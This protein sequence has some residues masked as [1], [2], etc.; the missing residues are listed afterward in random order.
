MIKNPPIK[1]Y[2]AKW[3]LAPWI[4]SHFPRHT[5]YI[6]V[7]GGAAGVLLQKPRSKLETYNDSWGAVVNFFRVLRNNE[8]E[9]I[10]KIELTPW[11]REEYKNHYEPTD[12]PVEAAR[13]FWVG[14]NMSIGSM[15]FKSCGMRIVKDASKIGVANSVTAE[16]TKSQLYKVSDRLRGTQIESLHYADLLERYEVAAPQNLFYFDPP[17]TSGERVT[18]NVYNT[19]WSN[20][21]HKEAAEILRNSKAYVIVSGYKS[22]LYKELYE[23][24]GWR[25]IDKATQTNGGS[26]VESLWLNP[27][28]ANTGQLKLF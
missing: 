9:L 27:A 25:R 10:R 23:D 14:C 8:A 15:A 7:C 11:A 16:K 21:D 4:I 1:Y 20:D 3:R 6:E 13:R 19:E 26:R 12:D 28:C 2:G 18:A 17:Y 5:H 22:E 24:Y